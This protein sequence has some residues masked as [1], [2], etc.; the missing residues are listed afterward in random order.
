M[1]VVFLFFVFLFA[2]VIGGFV[3]KI[4]IDSINRK[5]ELGVNL[6][7]L[8]CPRCGKKAVLFRTP[9]LINQAKWGGGACSNCGCEMDK[10]GNEISTDSDTV[11]IPLQIEQSKMNPIS[12]F[13]E[14]GKTPLERV[15][16]ENK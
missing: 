8:I 2:L 13:D 1:L 10:W 12:T 11:K 3:L 6:R 9:N 14:A 15:F 16:E 7:P 4:V 5:G